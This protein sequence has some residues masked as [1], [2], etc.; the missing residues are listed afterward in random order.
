[1]EENKFSIA[2][3]AYKANFLEEAIKSCLSQT[4]KNFELV[5]VDD[6]SPEDLKSIVAPFLSDERVRYYRNEKNFGA[7]DVV[8][9]WNRAL[10]F[11]TGQYVICMGD[12]DRLMPCCLEE[13]AKL[14]EKYPGTKAFHAWS[15]IIDEKGNVTSLLESRPEWESA[16]SFLWRRWGRGCEQFIGDFCFDIE[17][18]RRQN[19]FFK[20]PLAWASDDI[21]SFRAAMVNGIANTQTFCFQYRVNS[22]TISNSGNMDIKLKAKKMEKEWYDFALSKYM[23]QHETDDILLKFVKKQMPIY[24]YR[25]NAS[26]MYHGMRQSIFNFLFLIKNHTALDTSLKQVVKLFLKAIKSRIL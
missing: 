20:Q 10:S 26:L 21:S 9:N 3:P 23:C 12:D 1:M 18:L 17:E 24:F 19:G 11:C 2:I 7:V 8:D 13:Y 6:F 25:E 15:Q 14:I 16:I 5:I 22:L 4:Y